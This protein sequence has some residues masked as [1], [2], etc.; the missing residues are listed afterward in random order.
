MCWDLASSHL[1]RYHCHFVSADK[2]LLI[3]CNNASLFVKLHAYL[4]HVFCVVECSAG[5]IA[6]LNAGGLVG[7][8][9]SQPQCL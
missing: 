4:A 3:L 6:F 1:G 9:N 2:Q 7:Y 5:W 8:V